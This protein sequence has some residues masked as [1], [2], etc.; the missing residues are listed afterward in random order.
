MPDVER[1][2]SMS[3]ERS[4]ET[5][6]IA[7]DILLRFSANAMKPEFARALAELLNGNVKSFLTDM[8]VIR[9]PSL[10]QTF[11]SEEDVARF[12]AIFWWRA[13]FL[14]NPQSSDLGPFDE[15]SRLMQTTLE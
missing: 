8:Y 11:K 10:T 3:S 9:K 5:E 7:E 6:L 15:F 2:A 14:S 12:L 1:R 13:L 4:I